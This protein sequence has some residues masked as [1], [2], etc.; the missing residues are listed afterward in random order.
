MAVKEREDILEALVRAED[1]L[2]EA[3]NEL[4][5]AG[6][7]ADTAGLTLR[8]IA[9]RF[10]VGEDALV[11]FVETIGELIGN[12]PLTVQTARRAALLAAAGQAW[13]NELGPLL[14][15]AQVRDLLDGVSRQRVDELLRAHR[16]IGL[17]E[18]SG[19]RKFPGFQFHDGRPLESL[20]TAYWTVAGG[21]IDDW[22]AA[23]WCV[24][25]DEALDGRTPAQWALEG[26]DPARLARIARQDAARLAQ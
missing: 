16:L 1:A 18:S 17:R 3:R 13:E 9:E 14:T 8:E 7:P 23:S 25:P 15:S 11:A 12:R 21:A 26:R 4:Q 19:R 2:R 5:D 10:G 22:T 20:V 24:S 6:A